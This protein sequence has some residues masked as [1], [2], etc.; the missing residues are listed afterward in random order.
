MDRISTTQLP[1]E[2]CGSRSIEPLI[3]AYHYLHRMPAGILKC[4]VLLDHNNITPLGAAVFSN[5]RIQYQNK[6]LD[7]SRLW[8]DDRC[9]KNTE[10][11]FVSR[12]IKDLQ[13]LFTDFEGIVTWAD[14]KQGHTGALYRACNFTFD[15]YSRTVNR[16]KGLF[17][18]R[19]IYQ[20]S[21]TGQ[22]GVL[23]LPSDVPKKRFIY[24]FD[25]RKRESTRIES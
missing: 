15:G 25:K 6:Y 7:F 9:P 18:G 17:T 2:V 3:K 12:C 11:R 22:L 21:Y 13:N 14:P 20:R 5:G 8:V 16:Y 23:R 4:F 19:T 10:S 1:I 24:Y